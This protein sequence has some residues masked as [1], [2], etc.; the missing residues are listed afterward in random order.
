MSHGISANVVHKWRR[1]ASAGSMPLADTAFIAV[2][3]ST[4]MATA[5]Q[6]TRNVKDQEL[7][8]KNEAKG[9]ERGVRAV[10]LNR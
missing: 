3:L 9:T 10:H 5:A 6:D 1:R 8:D 7:R 4:P 2:A